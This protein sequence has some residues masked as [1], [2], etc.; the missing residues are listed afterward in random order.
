MLPEDPRDRRI[1][2]L[3]AENAELRAMLQ[4]AMEQIAA[5]SQRLGELETKCVA[6]AARI[7]DLEAEN[8]ELRAE[9][10]ELKARLTGNSRNSSRPPSSDPP[11]EK[12]RKTKGKKNAPKRLRGGQ[13]GHRGHCREP[14][15]PEQ[16]DR[17]LNHRPRRCPRC[18]TDLSGLDPH[19]RVHQVIDLQDFRPFVTEHRVHTLTCTACGMTTPGTLSDDVPKGL[20]SDRVVA[21]LSLFTGKYK[22]SKRSA[23]ELLQDCFGLTVSAALVT[24]AER[25]T[26][27]A[28]AAPVQ[29]A[30]AHVQT[31]PIV[32]ADETGWFEGRVRAWLWVAATL[33]VT[34]FRIVRHRTAEMARELLGEQF[35]GYLITDRYAGYLWVD[36]S[37]RQFCWA[38]LLRAIQGHIDRGGVAGLLGKR[39]MRSAVSLFRSWYWMRDGTLSRA[40]FQQRVRQLG[41]CIYVF[42]QDLDCAVR[43]DDHRLKQFCKE[44]LARRE[45]LWRF[46]DV[47][48]IEPTNN[49]AERSL[50]HAVL[51]RRS[52]Y[53]TQSEA[54]SRYV[55]RMLTT[56]ETLRLQRRPVFAFLVEALRAHRLG[57]A[58]PSLLPQAADVTP[59]AA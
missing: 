14:L 59:A 26:S 11:W 39:L 3:E 30:Q 6:Q 56:V 48:G 10:T 49:R 44:L 18:G 54:G 58:A 15:P 17:V 22:L 13:P 55:E 42:E 21:L 37:R 1:V 9:N 32:H 47:E 29:A 24:R 52:S 51:W 8:A 34:V 46:V 16:V 23:R 19:P 20:L 45:C 4:K 40:A 27:V 41:G 25:Q 31:A 43:S 53:G 28:L 12:L 50:R 7:A 33:T 5:L 38:H 35:A 36:D 57:L 2:Q